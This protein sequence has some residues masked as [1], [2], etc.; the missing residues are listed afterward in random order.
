[1]RTGEFGALASF[2]LGGLA[3]GSRGAE[4]SSSSKTRLP[5]SLCSQR[6]PSSPPS[7]SSVAA[8]APVERISAD[9]LSLPAFP[10]GPKTLTASSHTLSGPLSMRKDSAHRSSTTRNSC[11]AHLASAASRLVLTPRPPA[12]R[13]KRTLRRCSR[14]LLPGSCGRTSS[15]ARRLSRRWRRRSSR[16]RTASRCL[17]RF[18]LFDILSLT[19]GT[20]S[21]RETS[22]ARGSVRERTEQRSFC[23]LRN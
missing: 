1:M 21:H 3:D 16:S 23:A 12:H 2:E 20:C 17:R 4:R 6:C 19:R 11:V 18:V 13:S 10:P 14:S 9:K 22:R 8:C 15:L 5:S 7:P